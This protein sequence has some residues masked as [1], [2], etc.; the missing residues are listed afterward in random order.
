MR[1]AQKRF[2]R[3]LPC[4]LWSHKILFVFDSRRLEHLVSDPFVVFAVT[5]PCGVHFHD[6]RVQAK[7][8]LLYLAPTAY[9]TTSDWVWGLHPI[10]QLG[11][12]Y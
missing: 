7:N 12:V 2:G 8:S 6:Y 11:V 1:N 5:A 9:V 3:E 4:L 10:T